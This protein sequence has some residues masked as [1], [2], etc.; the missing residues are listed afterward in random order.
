MKIINL[1]LRVIDKAVNIFNQK[2]DGTNQA[3]LDAVR[4]EKRLT[5][6]CNYAEKVNYIVLQNIQKFNKR[7][8]SLLRRYIALFN[9]FD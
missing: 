4:D 5:K 1:A 6:A 2:G 3:I 9:R 8:Q 7:E